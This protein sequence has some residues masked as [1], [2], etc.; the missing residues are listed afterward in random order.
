M[1]VALVS[2]LPTPAAGATEVDW[3][4][5][6][7][8]AKFGVHSQNAKKPGHWEIPLPVGE[9]FNVHWQYGIDW[10]GMTIVR[11]RLFR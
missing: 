7:N 2:Q 9:K 11:S 8:V 3:S 6:D 4:V 10:E 1:K 5:A